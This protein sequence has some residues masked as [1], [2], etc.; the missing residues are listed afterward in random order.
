MNTKGISYICIILGIV[1]N[2]PSPSMPP[3]PT[4]LV[5]HLEP[6]DKIIKSLFYIFLDF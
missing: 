1:L 4:N 3:T 5:T 2:S 6:M